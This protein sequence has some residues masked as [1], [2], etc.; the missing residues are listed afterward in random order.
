MELLRDRIKNGGSAVRKSLVR[1][2]CYI[3]LQFLVYLGQ[4]VSTEVQREVMRSIQHGIPHLDKVLGAKSAWS[5]VLD[6]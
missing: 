2:I 3:C 1:C 4:A 5:G 6:S